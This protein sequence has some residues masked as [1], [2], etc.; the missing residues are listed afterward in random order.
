MVTSA[1][2]LLSE[3]RP[4]ISSHPIAGERNQ[5]DAGLSRIE[6]A[7]VLAREAAPAQKRIG[8]FSDTE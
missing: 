8:H 7:L 5:G 2:K 4:N 6:R 3:A 1:L